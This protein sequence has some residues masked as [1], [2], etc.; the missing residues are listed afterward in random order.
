MTDVISF[1]QNRVSQGWVKPPAPNREQVETLLRCAVR[2]PDHGR[3]KP[4]RFVV[5][6]GDA[7]NQLSLAFEQAGLAGDPAADDAKRARWRKMP[8]RAPMIIVTAARTQPNP[9]VP[10]WEQVAA[11]IAAT[12]NI[13]LAAIAQGFGVIWRT[14]EMTSSPLVKEFLGLAPGDQI[15]SFLY[16]GTPDGAAH[17]P[18]FQPLE[19]CAEFRN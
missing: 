16:I 17:P 11:V 15:V 5:L 9:K 2:A 14:G 6:S 18:E 8:L 13:L 19:E 1:L 7:L 12:Q 4:W 3:M 10:E